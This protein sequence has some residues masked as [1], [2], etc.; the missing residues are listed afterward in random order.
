M[1]ENK[2]KV[3]EKELKLI[4]NETLRSF[5]ET[6]LDEYVPDYFYH[7]PASST[8]KYHPAYSLGEG[9]LVRHTKAA[10]KLAYDMLQLE[11]NK[12]F[13]YFS[14][15]VIAA[16]ILHDSVKLGIGG[17]YTVSDHPILAAEMIERANREKDYPISQIEAG[18][19]TSLIKSHM[20]QWNTDFKT[21]QEVLPKPETPLQ[22]FVHLCDYLAS[23]KWLTVELD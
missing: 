10:V 16:L 23:R 11:Q 9:G 20:G 19:L 17:S 21:K 14:N 2:S 5:V 4:K 3:F 22:Q 13:S 1:E 12:K 6:C 8:G 18:V 7:I 15:Q